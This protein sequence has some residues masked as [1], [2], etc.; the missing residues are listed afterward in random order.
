MGQVEENFM[1]QETRK[2]LHFVFT[3]HSS[4]QLPDTSISGTKWQG[5]VQ[6]KGG[7]GAVGMRAAQLA[8][9]A[10]AGVMGRAACSL[11][12]R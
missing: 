5:I 9:H 2:R 12:Q 7:G 10:G 11:R 4:G 1:E 6:P 8:R 3:P